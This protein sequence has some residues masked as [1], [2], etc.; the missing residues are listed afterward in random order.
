MKNLI[1]KIKELETREFDVVVSRGALSLHQTQRNQ[2]KAELIEAF[3]QDL[4][5]NL[6]AAGYLV[7][8]T[9]KGPIV[10]FLNEN[11][12]NQILERGERADVYSGCISVQFDAIMKN[13]DTD[14]ASEE[15]SY[16]ATKAEKERKAD[17]REVAKQAKIQRD[18]EL[19]AE[20]ARAREEEIARVQILREQA[21]DEEN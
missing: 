13:L 16:L 15:I 8:Q 18:A 21:A 10:E 6:E 17:E 19:R 2:A 1:A 20:K 11:V 7:Y 9:D 3:Y 12:E 4:Q 14:G 5:E